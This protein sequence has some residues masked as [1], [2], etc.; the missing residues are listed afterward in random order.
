MKSWILGIAIVCV[1]VGGV[2][3]ISSVMGNVYN[4]NAYSANTGED[5][6]GQDDASSGG[7]CGSGGSGG[8]CCGTPQSDEE[9]KAT[10][11]AY[12]LEKTG[13][14]D[15]EVIIENFGC[16]SEAQ[17]IKD[18]KVVMELRIQSGVATEI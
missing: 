1:L 5:V 9:S 10:A 8:D 2:W 3:S 18:G 17:I 16:H 13:D 7:G 14:S 11:S 6:T 15:F 4:S 12:Y